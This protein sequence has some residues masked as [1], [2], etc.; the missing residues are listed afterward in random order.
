[1]NAFFIE[2]LMTGFALGTYSNC[3]TLPREEPSPIYPSFILGAL[4][5]RLVVGF[6]GGIFS[7]S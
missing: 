1:M 4:S 3:L 6:V 7:C 5:K 2:F